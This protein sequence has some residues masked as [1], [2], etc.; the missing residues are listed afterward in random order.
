[1]SRPNLTV[2]SRGIPAEYFTPEAKALCKRVSHKHELS[3]KE[4]LMLAMVAAQAALTRYFHPGERSAEEALTLIGHI[5]DHDDVVAAL[6]RQIRIDD[7]PE[8]PPSIAGP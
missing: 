1:M 7:Q 3:D 2:V 4:V 6:H 8:A 5:L